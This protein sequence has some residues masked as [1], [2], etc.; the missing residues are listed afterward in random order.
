MR[1]SGA[2]IVSASSP[3]PPSLRRRRGGEEDTHPDDCVHLWYFCVPHIAPL[4]G[5]A[6]ARPA[7]CGDARN[8]RLIRAGFTASFQ[9]GTAQHY[10]PGGVAKSADKRNLGRGGGGGG[11]VSAGGWRSK[12]LLLL[13]RPHAR[14]AP[15]TDIQVSRQLVRRR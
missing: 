13:G 14:E 10:V 1:A 6:V 5:L 4:C 12:P 11:G 3:A 9:C 2:D 15:I 7:F 8:V